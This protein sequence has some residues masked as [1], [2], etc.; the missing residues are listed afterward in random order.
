MLKVPSPLESPTTQLFPALLRPFQMTSLRPLPFTSTHR[1]RSPVAGMPRV[2]VWSSAR[3][4]SPSVGKL[5]AQSRTVYSV[6]SV[7]PAGFPS[8]VWKT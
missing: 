8:R 2:T 6:A 4:K 7:T 1:V 5:G 3:L